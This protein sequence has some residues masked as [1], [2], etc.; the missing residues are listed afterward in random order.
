[1]GYVLGA[2]PQ[3]SESF[4][5]EEV[6]ELCRQGCEPRVVAMFPGDGALDGAPPAGYL[7]DPTVAQQARA[8]A[9]SI[10]TRPLRTA[11]ALVDRRRRLGAGV[12]ETLRL[13]PHARGLKA[14][15]H[16][17]AHFAT[18][19]ASFAYRLAALTGASFSVSTHAYDVHLPHAHARRKLAAARFVVVHSD[20]HARLLSERQPELG[21][22]LR[23]VRPGV[24]LEK[25][26]RSGAYAPNGP[27]VC[28]ARLVPKKGL[29]V[30]IEAVAQAHHWLPPVVIV[31]DGPERARLETLASGSGIR[32]AGALAH[33]E[34]PGLL[35]GASALVLPCCATEAPP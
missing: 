33:G 25:F 31:G 1:M 7:G 17:H 11:L 34:I 21:S 6:R 15:R 12:R 20:Y 32:F 30:L 10:A 18:D 26:R 27:L 19:P 4:V 14:A 24:D 8:L 13:L 3:L 29:D 9:T 28:V 2:Y 23:V 22:S 16:L 35:E 5:V